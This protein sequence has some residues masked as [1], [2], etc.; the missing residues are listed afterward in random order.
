MSR[1][2]RLLE[3]WEQN[4]EAWSQ[5]VRS[6]QLESR[7]LATDRALLQVLE[8]VA[9]Q[10]VLDL[11]CGEGWLVRHLTAAG[12]EALGI[13]GSERL[14]HL[15]EAEGGGQFRHLS[16]ADF[17]AGAEDL[18]EPFDAIVANFALLEEDL[19]P[20]LTACRRHLAR[21]GRLVIQTLHP[22]SQ[23][24]SYRDGWREEDFRGLASGAW[25]PMPW[26]F[27]T[28]SS[29]ITL[30]HDSGLQLRQLGEPAHPKTAQPLS[31]LLVTEAR[32]S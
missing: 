5:A 29:W 15:A 24:E 13:D 8:E 30:L 11:G 17:A 32:L 26:Y 18:G 16:F 21:N 31:L 20:L 19:A 2:A 23:A 12:I 9:P 28:L 10:R 3:S 25:Q 1:K 22:W 14:I 7:R 4:A 27:R 6:G